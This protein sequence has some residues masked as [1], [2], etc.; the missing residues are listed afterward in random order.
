MYRPPDKPATNP[1]LAEALTVWALFAA[2]AAAIL[3]TYSWLPEEDSYNF[4][5]TG[6]AGGLGRAL[7]FLAFPTSLVAVPI[8][9]LAAAR[10]G[11]RRARVA[12]GI[13]IALSLTVFLPGNIEESDLDAKP[14]NAVTA[15]GVVLAVALT[16][17]AWRGGAATRWGRLPGDRFRM[18]LAA[19][20]FAG[21]VPWLLAELGVYTDD[22]SVLGLLFTSDEPGR[23][24]EPLAVHLGHHHGLDGTLLAIAALLLSRP[25]QRLAAGMLRT[26][27]GV[28]LSLLVVY[29][30]GNAVQ[31]FWLE[32]FVKRD[33]L[34]WEIPAMKRPEL[35]PVWGV[36]VLLAAV[37]YLAFRSFSSRAARPA[38]R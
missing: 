20:L 26:F 33:W 25:L 13:A 36:L 31:D 9:L 11:T 29:G 15:A 7:V 18:L 14:F 37:I 17:A 34:D 8:A 10:L 21:S 28:Y 1:G 35:E 19:V 22:L 5:A 32:Q 23:P 4:D 16:V 24:G 27:L 6:I 3:V 38:P 2:V 12:A 30:L